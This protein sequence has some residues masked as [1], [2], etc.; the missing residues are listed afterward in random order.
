MI[1]KAGGSSAATESGGEGA[2]NAAPAAAPSVISTQGNLID[3][4][5]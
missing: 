4:L 1:L 3:D 2:V 5:L